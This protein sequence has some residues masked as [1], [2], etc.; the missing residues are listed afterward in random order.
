VIISRSSLLRM[1]NVADK[2]SRANQNTHF[3]FHPSI[4]GAT[5]PSRPWPPS[6]DASIH[7]YF[8]LFS[9]IVSSPAAVVRPTEP[10]LRSNIPCTKNQLFFLVAKS[11]LSIESTRGISEVFS[12]KVLLPGGVFTPRPTPNL[13]DHGVPFCLGHYL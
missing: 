4:Y 12:T 6:E 11:R 2:S 13:E 5:A 10:H 8:Q 3:V 1:S 9:F 7:P